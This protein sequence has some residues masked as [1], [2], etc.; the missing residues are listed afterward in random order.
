MDAHAL[1]QLLPAE[2]DLRKPTPDERKELAEL[3]L[4]SRELER[5][6]DSLGARHEGWA[7]EAEVIDM[8]EQDIAARQGRSRLHGLRLWAPSVK[9][10]AGAIVTVSREGDM[11]AFRGLVREADRRTLDAARRKLGKRG[12]GAA[13][14]EADGE[15]G[16][17]ASEEAGR[18]EAAQGAEPKRAK[19]SDEL[20]RRL[21]AQQT[22]ALQVVL[23]RNVPVALDDE[24]RRAG[25]ALQIT[26]QP[27]AHALTSA[28]ED[29]KAAPASLALRTICDTWLVRLPHELGLV[30]LAARTAAGRPA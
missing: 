25:A 29:L 4:R 8:E 5:Q 3:P 7:D 12:R 21:A 23:A 28:A 10:L 11:E 6:G 14:D 30:R 17:V 1:R 18:S 19:F 22:L 20:S 9:A 13:S 24:Y 26:A 15:A 27:A 2:Y 16:S